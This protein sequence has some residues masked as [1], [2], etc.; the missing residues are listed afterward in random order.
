MRRILCL[1]GVYHLKLAL[2][3]GSINKTD[4]EFS[5][6]YT[7]GEV[8]LQASALGSSACTEFLLCT[9]Y[10]SNKDGEELP[11]EDSTIGDK[12]INRV[13][14]VGSKSVVSQMKHGS[15]ALCSEAGHS[16]RLRAFWPWM[17]PSSA[18]YAEQNGVAK[19]YATSAL[20]TC[21]PS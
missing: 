4:R 3:N 12:E 15:L 1:D 5:E 10:S 6:T 8:L 13:R 17:P 11:I 2:Q 19:V 7:I 14:V 16:L 21:L 20:L 9:D 18:L